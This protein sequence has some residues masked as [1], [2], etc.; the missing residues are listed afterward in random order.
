MRRYKADADFGVRQTDGYSAAWLTGWLL[1]P[2][3]YGIG[4][5]AKS[6]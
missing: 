6:A 5:T 1:Q 4:Q 2:A 3:D